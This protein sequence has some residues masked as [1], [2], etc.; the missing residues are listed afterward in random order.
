MK[1]ETYK[2]EINGKVYCLDRQSWLSFKIKP[3]DKFEIKLNYLIL[4]Q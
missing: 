4:N 1:T 2:A 3:T